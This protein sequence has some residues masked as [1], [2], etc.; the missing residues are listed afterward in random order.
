[1]PESTP[2][3]MHGPAGHHGNAVLHDIDR[4]RDALR[5]DHPEWWQDYEDF[6]PMTAARPVCEALLQNAPTEWA[7]GMIVGIMLTRQ[8]VANITGREF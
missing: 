4:N 5:R 1:M 7:R 8:S 2:A 3:A 6:D